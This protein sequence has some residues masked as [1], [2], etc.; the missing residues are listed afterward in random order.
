MNNLD[1]RRTNRNP[2]SPKRGALTLLLVA[3]LLFFIPLSPVLGQTGFVISGVA[4]TT[5]GILLDTDESWSVAAEQF[6]NLRLTAPIGE[7]GSFYSAFNVLAASSPETGIITE[8]ELERL[9]AALQFD[10]VDFN[11]GL[12]RV[13]FGY[14]M[15]IRPT[16]IINPRNPLFPDARLR[17]VMATVLT[18]Y[19]R[20]E[21]QVQ[22]FAVQRS[23]DYFEG[24]RISFDGESLFGLSLDHHNSILSIQGLALTTVPGKNPDNYRLQ[25]GLSLKFDV[26]VGVTFDTLITTDG[27]TE[28]DEGRENAALAAALGCD[29]SFLDGR[30]FLLAQYYY[31]SAGPLSQSDSVSDFLNGEEI[32]ENGES[33]IQFIQSSGTTFLRRHYGFLT[34]L[35]NH[36]DYARLQISM[37]ASLTDASIFPTIRHEIE[38]VQAVT[39]VSQLVI[40]FDTTLFG[41]TD[42]GEFGPDVA[43]LHAAAS[44]SVKY[45]F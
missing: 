30:I 45:R 44:F 17:G 22:G 28:F 5:L 21:L 40:P 9:Y 11:L 14:G 27:R 42:A 4:E 8:G 25:L 18:W 41:G 35:Y 16:D 6:A 19:P 20:E 1:P 38:P 32:A 36:S 13:P 23:T 7:N 39:V 15:G 31:T 2:L 34:L 43:G 24:Q 33:S 12:M 29:Y 3:I 26:A 37:L 10:T